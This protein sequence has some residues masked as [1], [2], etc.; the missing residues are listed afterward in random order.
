M[1]RRHTVETISEATDADRN[2]HASSQPPAPSRRR[3]L[4]TRAMASTASNQYALTNKQPTKA[5]Q[6]ERGTD[7]SGVEAS[8]SKKQ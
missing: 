4:A 8:W 6:P 7:G 1:R 5:S 3:L 2:H